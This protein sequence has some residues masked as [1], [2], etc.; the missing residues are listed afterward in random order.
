MLV[1]VIEHINFISDEQVKRLVLGQFETVVFHATIEGGLLGHNHVS[2][3]IVFDQVKLN[4]GGAYNNQT[5]V[6]EAPVPG[7]YMF[8]MSVTTYVDK[9]SV[10]HAVI[11]K[12]GAEVG[13]AYANGMAG[14]QEQGSVS[15]P[16]MLDT[17][18][19]VH[20]SVE[21][22]EDISL[23]GDKLTSF[24]GILVTPL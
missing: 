17:G 18:E 8:S 11:K 23:W 20:V 21:R 24:M 12:N 4:V 10:I 16:L 19:T 9:T 14:F 2:Q 1:Y 13:A 6:F 7:I 5:G 15:V 3:M 22:H